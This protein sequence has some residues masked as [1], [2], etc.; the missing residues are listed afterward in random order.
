M[1]KVVFKVVLQSRSMG[2]LKGARGYTYTYLSISL[3]I[4][5]I[6]IYHIYIYMCRIWGFELFKT[7][8]IPK[9]TPRISGDVRTTV[10]PAWILYGSFMD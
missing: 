4:Y 3:Y 5:I 9:K 2:S 10:P 7:G 8:C 1:C 6:Y